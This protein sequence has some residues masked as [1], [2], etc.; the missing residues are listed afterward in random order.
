MLKVC[1][2]II[3]HIIPFYS[4]AQPDTDA[5]P[6]IIY[7]YDALCGWC[8][9][10]SPVIN[11]LHEEFHESFDFIV[12]SGGM[13]TGDRIGPI[14]EVA[15]YI[16]HAYR[17][18]EKATGVTFG[19]AFLKNVLEEG[20]AVFTSIPP[21]L[22]LTAFKSRFPNKSINFAHDLQKAIYFN[23][24]EPQNEEAFAAIAANY[25]WDP[26]AFLI[27][28]RSD[29]V[30]SSTMREFELVKE[31]GVQGFPTLLIKTNNELIAVSRGYT[32]LA[33]LR[34]RVMKFVK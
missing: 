12:L 28:M 7:V 33:T 5:K 4:M 11:A 3:V 13:I 24:I 21:A 10:F 6:K 34:K 16:K 20:T 17:D 15:P 27:E 31:W 23:G 29:S 30:H 1:I 18:V 32:D 25:G 14:G 8:Y 2:L 19:S 22:A 26:K 9:G